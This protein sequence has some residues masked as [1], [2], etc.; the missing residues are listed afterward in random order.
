MVKWRYRVGSCLALALSVVLAAGAGQ[1]Q[2]RNFSSICD[3]AANGGGQLWYFF[4]P[5]NFM[6]NVTYFRSGDTLCSEEGDGVLVLGN[7]VQAWECNTNWHN[8]CTRDTSWDGYVGRSQGAVPSSW[9]SGPRRQGTVHDYS[10]AVGDYV[11]WTIY[12]TQ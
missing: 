12:I 1:A 3:G 4:N 10:W 5:N 2:S 7:P 8:A 6:S 9:I 11:A